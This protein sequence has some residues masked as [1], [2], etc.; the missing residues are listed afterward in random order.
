MYSDHRVIMYFDWLRAQV[1]SRKLRDPVKNHE[2]LLDCLFDIPF[3]WDIP[4]DENRAEDGLSLRYDYSVDYDRGFDDYFRAP[5][6]VLEMMVAL[7]LRCERDFTGD[8]A[9]GLAVDKWFWQMIENMDLMKYTDS[10]FIR[11][12]VESKVSAM[13]YREYEP[14]GKGGL[15]VIKDRDVDVRDMEIWKQMMCYISEQTAK[16]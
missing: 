5:C 8:L 2:K 15:F 11:D 6:N 13:L 3:R 1:G 12:E 7:S 4:L 9:A 16:R 14:N 10:Y